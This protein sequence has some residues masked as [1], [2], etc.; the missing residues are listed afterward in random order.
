MIRIGAKVCRFCN[1]RFE[2]TFDGSPL[3]P[4][5]SVLP[6]FSNPPSR[7]DASEEPSKEPGSKD[8]PREGGIPKFNLP[9][10]GKLF[11]HSKDSPQQD[12][13]QQG[14]YGPGVREQV[15]EV[16]VRQAL[17]GAPWREICAGPM[18]VNNI[19]AQEV[20]AEVRRRMGMLQ[21]LDDADVNTV[22]HNVRKCDK[23]TKR[24]LQ[25]A[26]D[27]ASGHPQKNLPSDMRVLVRQLMAAVDAIK[28]QADNNALTNAILQNEVDSYGTKYDALLDL[29]NSRNGIIDRLRKRLADLGVEDAEDA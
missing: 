24:L 18:H 2:S 26:D 10:F 13:N 3:E 22:D 9:Q 25:I 28:E 27:I 8:S 19:T 15:F 17:A 20:E 29:L 6:D 11:K 5:F 7:S 16:I 21:E 14:K 4:P 12:A 1:T 23:L